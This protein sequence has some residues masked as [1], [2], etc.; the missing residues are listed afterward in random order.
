MV[1]GGRLVPLG[2]LRLNALRASDEVG[3]AV[4]TAASDS[5]LTADGRLLTVG[6]IDEQSAYN[7]LAYNLTITDI[8]TYHVGENDVLVHNTCSTTNAAGTTSGV[9]AVNAADGVYMGSLAT[10]Q[11]A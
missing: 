6:G 5:V 10:F 7:G 2:R 1:P 8:H 9:Y 4:T 3:E 11:I